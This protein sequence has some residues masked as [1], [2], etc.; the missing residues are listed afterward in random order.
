[1]MKICGIA[2]T[3]I[4]VDTETNLKWTD[5]PIKALGVYFT[6]STKDMLLLKYESVGKKMKTM[7][8]Q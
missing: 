5:E 1:M 2:N 4:I 6:L 7:F 8:D 3:N